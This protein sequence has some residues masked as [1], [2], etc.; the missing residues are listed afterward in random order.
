MACEDLQQAFDVAS[1]KVLD[2][3]A[4][5]AATKDP[6]EVAGLKKALATATAAKSAADQQLTVCK[7]QNGLIPS[8]PA[9]QSRILQTDFVNPTFAPTDPNWN[10]NYRAAITLPVLGTVERGFPFVGKEWTQVLAPG[11]EYDS[12]ATLVAASGWVVPNNTVGENATKYPFNGFA[13]F[14]FDHPWGDQPYEFDFEFELVTDKQYQGLLGPGN[15]GVN[16]PSQSDLY[17]E[18]VAQQFANAFSTDPADG[19]IQTYL[20]LLGVEWESH[21]IPQTFR[22]NVHA[23]DRAVVAGRWIVDCGHDIARTEIHP[24]LMLACASAPDP[25]TTKAIFTSRPYLV[26]QTY[27]TDISSIYEDGQNDDG[28]FSL[29][30][31]KELVKINATIPVIGVPVFSWHIEAHPKIKSR[32]FK[33]KPQVRFIVRPGAEANFVLGQMTVS[34]QFTVRSG[35]TVEITNPEI[36]RVDVL[37]TMNEDAYVP[38]PLPNCN[39]QRDYQQAE[40]SNLNSQ[41]ASA[42]S[43]ASILSDLVQL[44]TGNVI[45][46]IVVS[47]IIGEGIYTDHYDSL[48]DRVNVLD[49]SQQ[50]VNVFGSSTAGIVQDDSQPFPFFG[51]LQ[52]QW[53]PQSGYVRLRNG[54]QG[55]QCINVQAGPVV[56]SAIQP[57]WWSADWVL[58]LQPYGEYWIRNRWQSDQRL[59]IQSGSLESSPIQSDWWSARWTFIPVSGTDQYQIRNVWQPVYLNIQGG[60]LAAGAISQDWWSARWNVEQD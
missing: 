16:D 48:K 11:D 32:P 57:D 31:A 54:W 53:I 38:P 24:P 17:N 52:A 41:A 2:L 15:L 56:S 33:G 8:T 58:E 20:G 4:Q 51:W 50:A 39:H 23:G 35:V 59:N 19:E 37:V 44:Y 49:S 46:S 42:F 14:P 18:F 10:Q 22:D 30:M 21:N 29:H 9:A 7:I 40:L 27:T 6:E 1:Q 47:G 55:D 5:I 26:G 25:A 34:F 3:D 60:A 13:D 45:G 36:D 12:T 43:E 28:D